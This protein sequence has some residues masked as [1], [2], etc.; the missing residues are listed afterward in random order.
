MHLMDNENPKQPSYFLGTAASKLP[1]F[2]GFYLE[3]RLVKLK[4][5]GA[6]GSIR[7]SRHEGEGQSKAVPSDERIFLFIPATRL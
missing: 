5:A 1:P 7:F 2:V 6:Q 4:L 3:S